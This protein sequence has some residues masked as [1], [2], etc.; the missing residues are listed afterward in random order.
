MLIKD[1]QLMSASFIS[2]QNPVTF[3]DQL[4]LDTNGGKMIFIIPLN[5][6]PNQEIAPVP[7]PRTKGHVCA[8]SGEDLTS[9]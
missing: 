6:V 2:H 7:L 1:N 5:V 4:E 9:A 8:V 3:T